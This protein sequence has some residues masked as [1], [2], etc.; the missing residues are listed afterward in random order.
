[1]QCYH[2]RSRS[3]CSLRPVLLVLVLLEGHKFHRS[4]FGLRVQYVGI[5]D[6]PVGHRGDYGVVLEA[7]Y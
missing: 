4:V 2:T 1:M 6:N 5:R 3:F 7:R